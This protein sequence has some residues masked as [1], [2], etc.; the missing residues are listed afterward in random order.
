M[1]YNELKHQ[2]SYKLEADHKRI[3]E[4]E[5]ANNDFDDIFS[6]HLTYIDCSLTIS[7][8]MRIMQTI[9]K[10]YNYEFSR[11]VYLIESLKD[12]DNERYEKAKEELVNKHIANLEFEKIVPPIIYRKKQ[13]G[14]SKKRT[15]KE[16]DMFPNEPKISKAEARLKAKLI[17]ANV[18]FGT[19]KLKKT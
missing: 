5:L 9:N 18:S 16:K 2:Y 17:G 12:V 10:S 14:S 7:N 4:R 13:K 15:Y 8:G 11:C 3:L 1:S 19:F 6:K